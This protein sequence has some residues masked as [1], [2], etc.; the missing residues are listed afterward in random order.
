MKYLQNDLNI[1]FTTDLQARSAA[2]SAYG[3]YF[4]EKARCEGLDTELEFIGL[5]SSL[6]EDF[7]MESPVNSQA[8]QVFIQ[9]IQLAYKTDQR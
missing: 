3:P 7:C 2:L 5:I 1:R 8:Y 9:K 4:N 6:P